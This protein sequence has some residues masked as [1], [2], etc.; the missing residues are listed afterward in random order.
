MTISIKITT[1]LF[2][3]IDNLML[4]FIWKFKGTKKLTLPHFK[5]NYK[6]A[7]FKTVCYWH[8]DRHR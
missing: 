2:A 4:K 6:A 7:V 5:T 1:D 3:E 8:E